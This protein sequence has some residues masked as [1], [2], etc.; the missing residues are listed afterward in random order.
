M[1]G[2]RGMGFIG[3]G[4]R[5]GV[6]VCG[7]PPPSPPPRSCSLAVQLSKVRESVLIISTDPA[8]NI[9]DAFDQKFSKVPTKV[10]GYDNLFAMVRR[11]GWG[12]SPPPH[13]DPLPTGSPPYRAPT[14]RDPHLT[15]SPLDGTPAPWDPDPMGPQPHTSPAPWDPDPVGPLPH[16]SPTPWAPHPVGPQPY[17]TP[18]LHI[19]RPVDPP[20]C[21]TPTLWDPNPMGPP[22]QEP[23]STEPPPE[24]HNAPP[25]RSTPAWEWR[26]S[27][28]SSLRR[29]T[30]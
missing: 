15:G 25:R 28:T 1:G 14:P 7:P 12:G 4:G 20:P 10:K 2:V 8:H 26:N 23:L 24:P 9:S 17:G 30:C 29:T 18:I 21:R 13:S 11:R 5:C 19:P 16:T 22:P 6:G 3:G 27:P